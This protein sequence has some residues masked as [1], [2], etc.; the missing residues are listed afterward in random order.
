MAAE[1][2][3]PEDLLSQFGL[4]SFRPA[5]REVIETVLSGR[6]CMCVMPTG[7]GKSLCFQLPA[8][9]QE[10][11]TLVVSPLIAL[12]KD[13]V[14]GL[15][16]KGISADFINSTLD[17]TE[18]YGRLDRLQRGEYDLLYVAPERFRS[19]RFC[20]ILR[21]INLRV[22]AIDEAHCISEWGHDFRPDYARLGKYRERLGNPTTI[23]LTATATKDVRDD[24]V[25]QLNLDDPKV[26]VAG[27]ARENL[28]YRVINCGSRQEKDESLERQ[29]KRSEGSGIIYVSARK[30]CTEVAEIVARCGRKVGYY[31]GRLE[32]AER[33]GMQERFMEDKIEVV[34]ATNAFG[35]GIDKPDVR[36]VTHFNMPGTL[37]AYY[38]EAGRA[39]RDGL[40]SECNLLYSSGDLRIQRFFIESAYPNRAVVR[41]VYNHLRKIDADPI[42]ITQP[43][44]KEQLDL[45]IGADGVGTCERLLEKSGIMQR[46]APHRNMSVIQIN[47]DLFSIVDLVNSR[48]RNNRKVVRAVE[49]LV[50]DTR[51]EP[52][53]IHLDNLVKRSELSL[54]A[55]RKSLGE[56]N[57]LEAFNYVPPFRGRAIH[58]SRRDVPFDELE[59]DFDTM[60][61]RKQFD[62]DKL[63]R[64]VSYATTNGCRQANILV[65]FGDDSATSCNHCDNCDGTSKK[66]AKQISVQLN[67]DPVVK[68]V[69]RIA[70]SGVARAKERVG[71]TLVAGML[72]GSRSKKIKQQRLD[73]VSTFGRLNALRQTDVGKILDA[74]LMVG[75]LEQFEVDRH[76]PLLRLSA[77]GRSVMK[78]TEEGSVS[79]LLP[80][81]LVRQIRVDIEPESL[82]EPR[83]PKPKKTVA[84]E[85]E[86]GDS[87]VDESSNGTTKVAVAATDVSVADSVQG[88]DPAPEGHV[89]FRQSDLDEVDPTGK[90]GLEERT[91]G[92]G[93]LRV[94]RPTYYW[95]CKLVQDGMFGPDEI[96][97]IRQIDI[98]TYWEHLNSGL[99]DGLHIPLN[100]AIDPRRLGL[101]AEVADAEFG[102]AF[103]ELRERVPTEIG[104]LELTFFLR[105]NPP[106]G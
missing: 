16:A 24:V 61:K 75:W 69:V 52:V 94:G 100:N 5:Q 49:S 73:K 3:N 27:F 6:D 43:D 58:F 105:Q 17:T 72:A 20:E 84:I 18:Q 31:H 46:L 63:D 56:L 81:K 26:F 48:A 23:A 88:V 68:T 8:I 106:T 85:A 39:G 29:I 98:A 62:Y 28:H 97:A 67:Q 92:P 101:I 95:T 93:D 1:T 42:E 35:M 12:M 4:S 64:M 36:W 32:P 83:K 66:D 91:S 74:M 80:K 47:S 40:P 89:E 54:Q 65:Y 45:D 71:K 87:I 37:E 21:S 90:S 59:I 99:D 19:R 14:D 70:L 51:F 33:R 55:V 86:N 11:T 10:G 104:D 41:K 78:D 102:M 82:P 22:L 7:G 34:V 60:E 76:R 44:L 13:Q 9:L 103:D 50:G 25:R 77:K 15:R 2:R 38:Q 57:K 30:R 79:I 96:V 53:Y